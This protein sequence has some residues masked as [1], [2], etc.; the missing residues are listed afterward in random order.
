[1]L[2]V[3]TRPLLLAEVA[4]VQAHVDEVREFKIG[5]IF[6]LA[7]SEEQPSRI[8]LQPNLVAK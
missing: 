8:R 2:L 7:S 1:M 5:G 3:E 6:P 4:L